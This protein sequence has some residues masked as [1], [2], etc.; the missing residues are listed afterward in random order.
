MKRPIAIG[1]SPNT[2]KDDIIL[3]LR[4]LCMPWQYVRGSAAKELERWFRTYFKLSYAVAFI[5]ARSALYA[6]L[7]CLHIKQGDEVILQAFTCVAVPN[8]IIATGAKPIYVDIDQSLNINPDLIEKKI[9][10]KTKAI[11]VQH[12]FAIPANMDA[13]GKI[14]QKYA[15]HVI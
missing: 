15:I 7:H 9:T 8:A 1:L 2:Q 5:N 12:T 10:K 14:A 4:L 3:A 11:I 13:I 6:I